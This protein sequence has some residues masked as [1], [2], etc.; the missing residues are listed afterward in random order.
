[1]D[2]TLSGP[3]RNVI[4]TATRDATPLPRRAELP[5][6]SFSILPVREPLETGRV[7]FLWDTEV[8]RDWSKRR[9]L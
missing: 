7:P 8:R 6:Q 2:H 5:R 4:E 3:V 9:D 1:M